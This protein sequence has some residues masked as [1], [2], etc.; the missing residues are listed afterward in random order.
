MGN[1][2]HIIFPS[3][4]IL[5]PWYVPTIKKPFTLTT[6]KAQ[7]KIAQNTNKLLN[8]FHGQAEAEYYLVDPNAILMA[9]YSI[10][11]LFS[12]FES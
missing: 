2:G 6:I 4:S 12:S 7:E 1:C 3:L 5:L 9:L 8:L 10:N 11:Y